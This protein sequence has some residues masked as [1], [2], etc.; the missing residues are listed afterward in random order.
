MYVS[1]YYVANP[2]LHMIVNTTKLNDE[3]NINNNYISD[4]NFLFF[5]FLFF[6]FF[7]NKKIEIGRLH[8][9]WIGRG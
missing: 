4:V 2:A 5:S 8:N 1:L 7:M 3:L 6:S 9:Y